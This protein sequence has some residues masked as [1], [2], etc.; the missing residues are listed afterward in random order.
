MAWAGN[1][2]YIDK[3]GSR[4]CHFQLSERPVKGKAGGK[5]VEGK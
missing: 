3:L 1:A 5:Q 4:Q 2:Q